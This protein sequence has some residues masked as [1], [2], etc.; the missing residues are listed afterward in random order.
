[1]GFQRKRN[2]CVGCGAEGYKPHHCEVCSI[3]LCPEKHGDAETLCSACPK[4]PCRRIKDLDK[5][6]ATKYG[7]SV[8]ENFLRLGQLGMGGFAT[9]ARDRFTCKSCGTLLCVHSP[10]CQECGAPNGL[11]PPR[12]AR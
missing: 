11:F 5:R 10:V 9:W 4:Y 2:R 7:E 8:I 3:K 1:M 6:Y 12:Q